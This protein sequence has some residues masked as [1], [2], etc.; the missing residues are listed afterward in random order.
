MNTG[1]A[2]FRIANWN[3]ERPKKRSVRTK[4]IESKLHEIDAELSILTETNDAINIPYPNVRSKEYDHYPNDQWVAIY[5]KSGIVRQLDIFDSYRT[6]CCLINS[7]II[8]E[9]IVYGTIIPYHMAGIKGNRYPVSGYKAWKYPEEDIVRQGKDWLHIQEQYPD[10]PMIVA[11]DFNQ[12][13]DNQ[14]K[15]Y[16]ADQVRRTLSTELKKTNLDC[17]TQI[18]FESTG[19]LTIDLV[20]GRVRRNVDHICLSKYVLTQSQSY[21]VG[22]WDHFTTDGKRLFDHNGVYVDLYL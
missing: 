9:L 18:S 21:Q 22:A 7:P 19:Q 11:G 20:K 10:I 2:T 1:S 16:G 12:V 15:G 3:F 4:L 14:T 6:V 8:G 17:V 13:I 5:S